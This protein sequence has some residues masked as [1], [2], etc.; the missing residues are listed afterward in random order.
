MLPPF[1]QRGAMY[2]K[3]TRPFTKSETTE[4][5]L[6]IHPNGFFVNV[7]V[8]GDSLHSPYN[9]ERL[10]PT[11]LVA[12][13][14]EATRAMKE[15]KI[16]FAN[17]EDPYFDKEI[18]AMQN[19]S[20]SVGFLGI[21]SLRDYV[22][23]PDLNFKSN[24]G[25][26]ELIQLALY[27]PFQAADRKELNHY[28]LKTFIF[29]NEPGEWGFEIDQKRPDGRVEV[30]DITD[31]FT[32]MPHSVARENIAMYINE[33]AGDLKL[34]QTVIAWDHKKTGRIHYYLDVSK[35]M[36]KEEEIEL[37]VSYDD[38]YDEIRQRKGYGASIKSGLV[39]SD[40]HF[41]T[42]LLRN[43]AERHK[44]QEMFEDLNKPIRLYELSNTMTTY[45]DRL[46][47]VANNLLSD[48]EAAGTRQIIVP[49]VQ[50]I[51]ALRRLE[52]LSSSFL[53]KTRTRLQLLPLYRVCFLTQCDADIQTMKWPWWSKLLNLIHVRNDKLLDARGVDLVVKLKNELAEEH[54]YALR[55]TLIHPFDETLWCPMANELVLSFCKEIV[56]H[57]WRGN[58]VLFEFIAK[59][60]LEASEAIFNLDL[61]KLSFNARA[62]ERF[63]V[64][65]EQ[66]KLGSKFVIARKGTD[67][68]T[69]VLVAI[70][71][72]VDSTS[73]CSIEVDKHWYRSKQIFP[74]AR[75]FRDKFAPEAPAEDLE[76][77]C[78]S[79]G[80]AIGDLY[81]RIPK[82]EFKNGKWHRGTRGRR[83]GPSAQQSASKSD[84]PKK[85]RTSSFLFWK[86]VWP[87][88]ETSGWILG[89]GNRPNDVYMLPPGVERGRGFKNRVD[90]FD[91]TFLALKCIE[92]DPRYCNIPKMKAL[93]DKYRA[94]LALYQK[95]TLK[96]VKVPPECVRNK[97]LL[98]DWL[99]SEVTKTN[100][101]GDRSSR[102]AIE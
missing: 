2:L 45:W 97:D 100:E 14:P 36:K 62:G 17:P 96:Q 29:S 53:A 82:Y 43:F 41:P 102:Q 98:V 5:L 94:C 81:T 50:Q 35:A 8:T 60:A 93:V 3:E 4:A 101:L 72:L 88:L 92:S 19:T 90:F 46:V 77:L 16:K 40:D 74:L 18:E 78:R 95:I 71:S 23:A 65:R 57:S 31:D 67:D 25:R 84:R 22:D 12:A 20:D 13:V 59:K 52:W 15:M 27:G 86:V 7:K 39:K 38:H 80:L 11:Y 48:L 54:C 47:D 79:M 9:C 6:A 24:R 70:D 30:A 33:T 87:E 49:Y 64:A 69:N 10:L 83:K 42:L 1:R 37:L 44:M 89:R 68:E 26:W 76:N 66:G 85:K 21:H 75:M 99:K 58:S 55:H 32:G 28:E 91:S 56:C 61:E 63:G 73:A 34:Q 51:V